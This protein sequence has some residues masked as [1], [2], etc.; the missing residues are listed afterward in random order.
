MSRFF[1]LPDDY[2][3]TIQENIFYLCY[4]GGGGFTLNDLYNLPILRRKFFVHLLVDTIKKENTAQKRELTK[5]QA[6]GK[7]FKK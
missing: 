5:I 1:G 2:R 3:K 7:R 6:K 4:R